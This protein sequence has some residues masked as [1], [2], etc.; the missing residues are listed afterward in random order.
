MARVEGGKARMVMS[1]NETIRAA[2]SPRKKHIEKQRGRS[3]V[4]EA[5]A[6]SQFLKGR[7][8]LGRRGGCL[9]IE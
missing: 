7:F 1:R 2:T 6:S 5:Y 9:I 8:A 4:S 3:G